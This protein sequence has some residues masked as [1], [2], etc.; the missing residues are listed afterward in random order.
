M[1]VKI[2]LPA[3]HRAYVKSAVNLSL[4]SLFERW[5]VLFIWSVSS[6]KTVARSLL[7]S[8]SPSIQKIQAANFRFVKP[9]TLDD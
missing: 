1:G 9:I 6:V 2:S 8:F 3:A 4:V 7:P 5:A